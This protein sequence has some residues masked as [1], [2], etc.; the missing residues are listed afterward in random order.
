MGSF[1]SFPTLAAFAVV[2]ITGRVFAAEM[3]PAAP[4]PVGKVTDGPSKALTRAEAEAT[5]Q[6]ALQV[7]Q[8]GSNL[9]ALGELLFDRQQRTVTI[10]A[11]VNLRDTVIEYALVHTSGKTHESLLA[12]EVTAEQVHLACLL[13]GLSPAPVTGAP[14][15]AQII[16]GTNE[17]SIAV[18]WP[19]PRPRPADPAAPDTASGKAAAGG[20]LTALGAE[21]T[22]S[23]TA[24]GFV[25]FALSELVTLKKAE[26]EPGI[27]LSAGGWFYNGSQMSET[28][29]AAQEEGS[30]ISL[31]RDPAAL[32]NN[33]RAQRDDDDAH[34]PNPAQLPPV[35]TPVRVV[36]QFAPGPSARLGQ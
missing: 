1:G 34:W 31:I 15:T 14:D 4:T 5:L 7:R 33:P 16:P 32:V 12:T 17:V 9:F 10:P 25:R 3:P 26:S 19:G 8:V 11:R 2:L 30:I 29:F 24:G 35:G 27:S 20:S 6:K 23:V 36:L 18:F 13:L 21:H 22:A 28:G